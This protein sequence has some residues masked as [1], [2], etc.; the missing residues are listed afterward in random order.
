M[1]LTIST[2]PATLVLPPQ[3][4][5][6][7]PPMYFT[8]PTTMAAVGPRGSGKT[9]NICLF[10]KWMFDNEYFTRFYVICPT[11]MSNDPLRQIPTRPDDIYT[12]AENSV[13]DLEEII[14]K[15]ENDVRWY[16]NITGEYADN[17]EKYISV[18]CDISKLDREVVAYLRGMQN[19]IEQYYE[20]LIILDSMMSVKNKAIQYTLNY[21]P[22]PPD[23][24]ID[25]VLGQMFD[26]L[27]PW[28]YPPPKIK[29]PV[30]L[31]FID[32]MSHSPIYSISRE[33]K[34]VNLTLRHRHI[35]GKGYGLSIQFAVQTFKTGVPKALRQN[36]M[37]F[38]IFKTNDIGTVMDI[39]EEVG[40]FVDKDNFLDLYHRAIKDSHDFLL[41]D[42][43]TKKKERAFRRGFD[44]FL[45]LNPASTGKRARQKK[46]KERSDDEYDEN[47]EG[48]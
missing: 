34:L 35:G 25:T 1:E 22:L 21:R 36:T 33:N 20:N 28:F 44:T 26:N 9:Y 6:R 29:R 18:E 14:A 8:L 32:D 40:A 38:L 15:V 5:T 17:Y 31:L 16:E 46:R 12:S 10:N 7:S 24:R 2:L 27:T 11:Y 4:T 19:E 23:K 41:I 43:N 47:E 45:L 3:V 48:V 42:M 39:Y 37:Q 13:R 30:P